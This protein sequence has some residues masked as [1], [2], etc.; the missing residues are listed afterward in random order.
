MLAADLLQR[1]S[2]GDKVYVVKPMEIRW[3]TMRFESTN[4]IYGT[5]VVAEVNNNGLW[6]G[7]PQLK[8]CLKA[9]HLPKGTLSYPKSIMNFEK[10]FQ[11]FFSTK[12]AE[13]WKVVELQSLEAKVEAHIE[14]MRR[15]TLT[16]LK[17]LK[18]KEKLEHYLQKY[19]EQFIKVL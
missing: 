12:E 3:K 4:I 15:K 1:A 11:C 7:Q 18:Q 14:E 16:K 13:I 9:T 17:K 6:S 2:I 10:Y 5:Y 19:P 8:M